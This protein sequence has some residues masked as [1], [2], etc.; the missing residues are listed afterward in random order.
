MTVD[1]RC[2]RCGYDLRESD[3]PG[4][5][6]ECGIP[7]AASLARPPLLRHADRLWVRDQAV[8]LRLAVV[9]GASASAPFC[10]ENVAAAA[11]TLFAVA[12]VSRVARDVAAEGAMVAGGA[13]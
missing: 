5:C 13:E 2:L 8:G 12:E 3:P 1:A 4:V 11:A 7:V 6:P 10:A 9:A